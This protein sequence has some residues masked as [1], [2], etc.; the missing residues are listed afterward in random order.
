MIS[1]PIP[2]DLNSFFWR[3]VA[4]NSPDEAK[5]SRAYEQ[6]WN[7]INELIRADYTWSGFER[8]VFY[9][10][11]GNG[12]FSDVSGIIGLD[13]SEDSRAFAL[14]DLDHDGRLEVLL[15]N[16]NA[17]QLRFL[18][19][20]LKGLPPAISFRLRGTKSNRDAIGASITIETSSGKQTRLLQAGS[21]FL[22]QHSKQI[23]FG[24]GKANGSIDAS[25]RWPSGLVQSFEELPPDHQISIEEGHASFS[26]EPFHRSC[27]LPNSLLF[28]RVKHFLRSRKPGCSRPLMHL[29]F[30]FQMDAAAPLLSRRCAASRYC[31][32]SQQVNRLEAMQ[33]CKN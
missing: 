16:R 18:K 5:P 13:F 20:Q 25:V 6:G 11:N 17:P 19:N 3:Q 15:K 32:I 14:A 22:S 21:G 29:T 1:G 23:F 7:A 10:N 8:N 27:H 30:H 33:N 24:L 9:A 31:S 4:A 26:A 2:E 12:T 28:R